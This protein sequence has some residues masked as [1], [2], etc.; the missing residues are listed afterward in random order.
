MQAPCG[1]DNSLISSTIE[2]P[3]SFELNRRL[4]AAMAS[5]SIRVNSNFK[6]HRPAKW[7]RARRAGVQN[8]ENRAEGPASRV[9]RSAPTPRTL[10]AGPSALIT[11]PCPPHFATLTPMMPHTLAKAVEIL[12][13]VMTVA[14]MGYFVAAIVAARVFLNERRAPL[15]GLCARREH[16]QIAQ[17]P[18]PRDA[19]CLPQPLPA[20]LSWRV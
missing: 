10:D 20:I 12:T 16:S 5:E 7:M 2:P 11:D 6:A 19:R 1:T 9:Q 17:G 13:T 3:R 14:G 4:R 18:R 15:A 8:V